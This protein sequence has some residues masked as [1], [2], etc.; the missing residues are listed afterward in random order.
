[1][2]L[3]TA[4][5]MQLH[6]F[7]LYSMIELVEPG[8]FNGYGDFEPSR[9]E[10]AAVNRAVTTLRSQR[11]S[12]EAIDECLEVLER[13]R[14]RSEL[15]QAATGKQPEREIVAE[16]LSR[17]HRLSRGAGSK[18]QGRDR[19]L[20]EA[21]RAPDRGDSG[22][23]GA[24]A[25]GDSSRSTS[26]RSTRCAVEASRPLSASFW[27]SFQK[28]LCSSTRA[29]AGSLET[30]AQAR[31]ERDREADADRFADDPDLHRRAG[32]S[33]CDSPRSTLSREVERAHE[34]LPSARVGSGRE[35]RRPRR[36]GGLGSS[37]GPE[38]EGPDLQPVP[39]ARSR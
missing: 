17:C 16:W 23:G 6:D 21:G 8:L 37:S 25:R 18:P 29:L 27:S 26:E 10:I 34:R 24:R 38:R 2:L 12:Q 9:A 30:R 28:M 1:M 19:W 5:P 14:L 3:L 33:C 22:D 11:P 20:Q 39:R 4:T 32:T 36:A 31:S 35:A 15:L 13:T 7:E